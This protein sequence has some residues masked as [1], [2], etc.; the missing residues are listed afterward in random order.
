MVMWLESINL[1]KPANQ[2]VDAHI[3]KP[4]IDYFYSLLSI[5]AGH[6]TA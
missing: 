1:G 6:A 4:F 3:L 5:I 2:R